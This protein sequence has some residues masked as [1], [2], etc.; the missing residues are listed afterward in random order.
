VETGCGCPSLSFYPQSFLLSC[1]AYSSTV[2]ARCDHAHETANPPSHATNHLDQIEVV[3]TVAPWFEKHQRNADRKKWCTVGGLAV[4]R[5]GRTTGAPRTKTTTTGSRLGSLN[6]PSEIKSDRP[7]RRTSG[8]IAN[9]YT[10]QASEPCNRFPRWPAGPLPRPV[11]VLKVLWKLV[12]RGGRREGGRATRAA[13][14]DGSG[15]PGWVIVGD[16]LTRACPAGWV[17]D[18]PERG[19]GFQAGVFFP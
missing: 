19:C 17:I 13:S 16:A 5:A 2:H 3:S 8:M 12:S 9:S 14:T 1:A 18:W 15:S 4:A 6:S 10:L 11:P 7:K